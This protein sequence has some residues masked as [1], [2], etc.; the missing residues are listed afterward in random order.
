M[1][2]PFA[3]ALAAITLLATACAAATPPAAPPVR[4]DSGVVVGA[5]E[6]PA[7]VFR[8]IP[9]AAPP[10]GRLRW[11]PPQPAASW[12]GERMATAV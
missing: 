7:R 10:V 12:Q 5:V 3:C 2:R 6:G 9:Y 11:R 4:I 8:A 1:F